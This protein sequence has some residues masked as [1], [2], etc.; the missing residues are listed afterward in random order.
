M[1]AAE[2]AESHAAAAEVLVALRGVTKRYALTTV[3]RDVSFDILRG[4]V[5]A[6]VGENG[7]GKSTLARCIAGFAEPNGGSIAIDGEVIPTFSVG[8]A[9]RRGIVLIHQELALAEHL[10]VVANLFLGHE[11]HIGSVLKERA[12]AAQAIEM[13]R[14]LGC[15]AAPWQTVSDLAVSD[16]QMV[17]IAKALLRRARLIIMDEPTAVLT[18]REANNLFAQIDRLRSEG[19]S[20]IYVSHKLDEVKRIADRVTV[21]RDGEFQGTWHTDQLSVHEIANLMVGREISNIYPSKK[22]DAEGDVVLSVS[23][24]R[25][26]DSRSDVT[27]D[28]YAGEILG[29]SG[30]VGSG[31]TEL[32]EAIVGLRERRQGSVGIKGRAVLIRAYRDALGAGLAYLTEDRKGRGLQLNEAIGPNVA[33]LQQV[34]SGATF[35]DSA[36]ERY[37]QAW[38]TRTFAIEAPYPQVVVGRLSGGNQQKVLLAKSFLTE[39]DVVVIDEPTRG[40]DVGTRAQIYQMLRDLANRGKAIVMISSDLQEVVGLSD[41]VMV[42]HDHA[43]AGFLSGSEVTEK[44]IVQLATGVAAR[45]GGN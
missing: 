11:L 28:V 18:P 1:A 34:L 33:A 30:L 40:I 22:Q 27:F 5:H 41:R 17:E 35:I 24:F 20:V 10:S 9:E 8:E 19:V 16:K 25:G 32:F 39:P 23:G 21:L 12:M 31:R 45:T 43:V 37:A 26:A 2:M 42:M 29:V 14:R 7:A 3:L 13:L 15:S 36:A 38:A 4:E 44:R 6:V